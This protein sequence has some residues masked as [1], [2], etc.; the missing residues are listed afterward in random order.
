MELAEF[1]GN[2]VQSIELSQAD[3][4]WY[5]ERLSLVV[6]NR[7]VKLTATEYQLLFP[8]RHRLPVPYEELALAVY[9]CEMDNK[10][11]LMLDKHIDRIRG[12]IRSTGYYVY[13][14]LNYGYILLP[15]VYLRSRQA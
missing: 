4:R 15:E 11:R 14:I 7:I 10:V 8:M 3:I 5:E 12:K 13:C 6:E 9:G 2:V 1:Q